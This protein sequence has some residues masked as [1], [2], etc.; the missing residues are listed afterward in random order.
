[1]A[2]VGPSGG[3]KS[4]LLGLLGGS[5]APTSGSIL[6]DGQDLSGLSTRQLRRHR[7][8]CGVISQGAPIVPQ[9]SV[10]ANVTAGRVPGWP[11]YVVLASM[12][13]PLRST[14]T[15]ALLGQVGLSDRQWERTGNLSGGEQQRVAIARALAGA[16]SVFLADEPTASL[17]PTTSRE[18]VQLLL[19]RTAAEDATLIFCTH[20]VS[21]VRGA[22]DRLVGVREGRITV[23]GPVGAVTETDLDALYAGSGERR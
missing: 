5:L 13:W 16:P 23:D 4:T 14:E 22:V 7:A 18:V 3:G 21:L 8:R 2:L 20:W 12:A 10:H 11:W 6:A 9:L 17:D 15:R 19:E 1:M